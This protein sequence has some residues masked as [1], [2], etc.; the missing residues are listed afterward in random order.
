M[1]AVVHEVTQ[2]SA[3]C[4]EHSWEGGVYDNAENL[5]NED[6]A[7]HNREFHGVP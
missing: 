1:A 2:Y 6:A 5:A 7:K 3:Y 4:V